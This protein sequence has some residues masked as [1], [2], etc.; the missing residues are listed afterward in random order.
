MDVTEKFWI[1]LWFL[2]SVVIMS[3]VFS[4]ALT[5]DHNA[6]LISQQTTCYGKVLQNSWGENTTILALQACNGK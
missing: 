1:R 6:E 5:S 4:I 2:I 3:I